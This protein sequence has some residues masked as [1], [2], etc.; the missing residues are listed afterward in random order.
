MMA[1]GV[2]SRT[3][4]E[5]VNGEPVNVPEVAANASVTVPT[6]PTVAVALTWPL[7]PVVWAVIGLT[8]P[9]PL[10]TENVTLTPETAF[11]N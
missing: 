10:V 6:L 11:P 7:E 2:A 4:A 9:L 8:E 3:V 5:N 1:V